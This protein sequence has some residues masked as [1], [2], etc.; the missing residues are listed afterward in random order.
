M[1]MSR[2]VTQLALLGMTL[3]LA[4]TTASAASIPKELE[5]DLISVCEAV[6]SD[7]RLKLRRAVKATG[8]DIKTLHAGLVCNGQDMLSF[9]VTHGAAVNAQHIARRVNASPGVLTAKR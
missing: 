3:S 1:F 5:K 4:A 7:K 2:R 6:K 9:A 8:L